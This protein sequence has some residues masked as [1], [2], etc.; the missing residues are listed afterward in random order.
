M[1]PGGGDGW[2]DVWC[3]CPACRQ[4]PMLPRRLDTRARQASAPGSRQGPGAPW[5]TIIADMFGAAEWPEMIDALAHLSPEHRVWDPPHLRDGQAAYRG[6]T[7]MAHLF[8]KHIALLS[9]LLPT[10]R[11]MSS[12]TSAADSRNTPIQNLDD[13]GIHPTL[14]GLA[15]LNENGVVDESPCNAIEHAFYDVRMEAG[16][17]FATCACSSAMIVVECGSIVVT[18]VV[19]PTSGDSATETGIFIRKGTGDPVVDESGPR[20]EEEFRLEEGKSATLTARNAVSAG[21]V[22][23]GV[24]SDK[25]SRLFISKASTPADNCRHSDDPGP[26]VHCWICRGPV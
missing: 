4:M 6:G 13:A 9:T 16:G 25:E 3:R 18:P 19:L 5:R 20:P 10:F 8:S 22:N 11:L 14:L 1:K 7:S 26:L 12:S 17:S 21:G 15:C 23:I 24:T 2:A